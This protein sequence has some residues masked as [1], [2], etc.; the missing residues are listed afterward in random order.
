MPV[1]VLRIGRA[2]ARWILMNLDVIGDVHGQY[3]KLVE[4][5]QHLGYIA[6]GTPGAIR[7]ERWSSSGI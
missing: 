5:L 6:T 1:L 4:L 2:T 3:N 7:I